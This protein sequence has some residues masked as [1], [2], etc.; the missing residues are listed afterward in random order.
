MSKKVSRKELHRVAKHIIIVPQQWKLLQYFP[1]WGH[2]E[3]D[4]G[5]N[6]DAWLFDDVAI[7]AGCRLWGIQDTNKFWMSDLARYEYKISD[8]RHS[9]GTLEQKK[10]Q[11]R[12][13][14]QEFIAWAISI[15]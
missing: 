15:E 11:A 4:L 5:W 8:L 14:M 1:V 12:A 9:S 3:G 6:W 2:G 13:I 7:V 10:K